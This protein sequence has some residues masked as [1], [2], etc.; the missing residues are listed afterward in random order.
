MS[1]GVEINLCIHID[2]MD[3]INRGYCLFWEK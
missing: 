2:V 1:K 3:P